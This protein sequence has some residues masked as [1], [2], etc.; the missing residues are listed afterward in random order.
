MRMCLNELTGASFAVPHA[1]GGGSVS[2]APTARMATDLR[3]PPGG[4]PGS[5]T[6]RTPSSAHASASCSKN[7]EENRPLQERLYYSDDEQTPP[8]EI[9][10]DEDDDTLRRDTWSAQQQQEPPPHTNILG[11][12][13]DLLRRVA[14]NAQPD[15]QDQEHDPAV[16]HLS[17]AAAISHIQLARP[18]SQGP[19]YFVHCIRAG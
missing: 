9:S 14:S 4:P 6:C 16:S 19:I 18:R 13:H 17:P 11:E 3:V 15:N 1:N 2:H 7:Q 5:G 12:Q 10:D 8:E